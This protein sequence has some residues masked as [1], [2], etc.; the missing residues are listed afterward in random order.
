[1]KA[2]AW[3]DGRGNAGV[4]GACAAH[5]VREDG[6]EFKKAIK[7]GSM[8]NNEA[9]YEGVILAMELALENDVDVLRVHCDSQV[10]VN[11][12]TG[13][14][15]IRDKSIHLVPFRKRAWDI[16]QEFES[17]EIVWVRREYTK[18]PDQ[19]CRDLFKKK[20]PKRIKQRNPFL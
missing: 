16:G 2:E 20:P 9:E 11:Q 14:Y 10:I 18:V 6:K 5:V 13:N 3:C 8:T 1:M 7:L 12:L 19:M 15:Q 17:V 4:E